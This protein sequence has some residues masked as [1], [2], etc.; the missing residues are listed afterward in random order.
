MRLDYH[1]IDVFTNRQFGGNQLA[2]FSDPPTGLRAS[3]MQRIAKELNLSETTF[4]FPPVAAG[5]CCRLRIFTPAAE[6]PMAGH[7]TIGSAYMLA[8][9]GR[10][11]PI[12]GAMTITIE[13]GV[14]P[15]SV[16]IRSAAKG[17]PTEVWMKQPTPRFLDI[18]SDRSAIAAMLSLKASDLHASA[19]MQVL[20]SGLPFLFVMINSLEAL[21]RIRFRHD[22]W[23]NQL[24]G[25]PGENVFVATTETVNADSSAHCRMFAPALGISEDPATGSASG[26]LGAYLLKYEL[27]Q[28]CDMVSEQGFEIGR[29]SFIRISVQRDGEAFSQVAVGG[30]CVYVGHGSLYIDETSAD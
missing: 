15:I 9:L 28:S 30:G 11:G 7:P 13:E 2:V 6:L 16:S 22:V 20:S 27:L 17:D 29:P 1:L 18:K 23:S 3:I 12:D 25:A 24:A 14:G 26:P 10:L 4:V 5:N 21:R 19:P 8:R